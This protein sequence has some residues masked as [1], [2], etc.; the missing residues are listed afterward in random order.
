MSYTFEAIG[1]GISVAVDTYCR[2]N[3]DGTMLAAFA[4]PEP[5]DTALDLGTGNGLIPLWWCRRHPPAR[6]V[7]VEREEA[8]A[9]LARKAIEKC[10]AASRIEL[11]V[12]DW[13]DTQG[14]KADV[15][16]CN[17]P[18]F[19]NGA[20]RPSD[21][22]LKRAARYEE[23]PDMLG[24][25]FSTAARL[26]SPRGKFCI[27]HRPE[28]LADVMAAAKNAGLTVRRLQFV[29]ANVEASPW[30]VLC[31][32]AVRGRLQV[33][34]AVIMSERGDHTAVYKRIYR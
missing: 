23:T 13:N 6:I 24:R 17:P 27:C 19:E 2:V 9:A 21:D 1:D 22:P 30:L 10:P 8:F 4:S 33:L 34:P 20:A 3:A 18:Y 5:Q 26:L 25:L 32:T 12:E 31:E 16:T 29:Q 11:R 28:R 15:I 7:A 14:I